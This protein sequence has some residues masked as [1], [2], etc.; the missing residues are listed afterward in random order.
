MLRIGVSWRVGYDGVDL[1]CLQ[2]LA[3][4]PPG[5]DQV[6]EQHLLS[7]EVPQKTKI[8]VSK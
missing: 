1:S 3:T 5:N 6:E 4:T 2:V 7:T 8:S